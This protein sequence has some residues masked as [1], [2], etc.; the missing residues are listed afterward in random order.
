MNWLKNLFSKKSEKD[1]LSEKDLCT[2]RK[3]PYVAV[4]NV[5]V[6]NTSP[7]NGYFELDWNTYFIS[8]LKK[9]GY[10]GSTEEEIVDQWLKQLC[11]NIAN[12]EEL[13]KVVRI[14]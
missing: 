1:R 3:E 8:D 9:A 13:N 6:D 10:S 14:V 2:A 12:E 5:H 11:K 4:I 7:G